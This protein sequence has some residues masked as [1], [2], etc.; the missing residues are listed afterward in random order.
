[1]NSDLTCCCMWTCFQTCTFKERPLQPLWSWPDIRTRQ[2]RISGRKTGW[3]QTA[4]GRMI[5][6]L[7]ASVVLIT[8]AL[9]HTTAVQ[10]CCYCVHSPMRTIFHSFTHCL[11]PRVMWSGCGTEYQ[12]WTNTHL[13]GYIFPFFCEFRRG[14]CS[15]LVCGFV[16]FFS[17]NFVRLVCIPRPGERFQ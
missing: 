9:R 8:T 12:Q 4:T 1:M 15:D 5:I 17:P 11:A 10:R 2:G 3:G 14:Q 7:S 16:G 13:V 6:R